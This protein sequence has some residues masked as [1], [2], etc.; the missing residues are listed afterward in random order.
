MQN[1]VVTLDTDGIALLELNRPQVLNVLNRDLM[2]DFE[3]ALAALAT[4]VEVRALLVTGRGEGFC[5]GADL[6]DVS[7][8]AIDAGVV[9]IGGLVAQLMQNYFNPMMQSLYGFPKPVICAVNG[10]AAGGGAAMALCADLV[11]VSTKASMKLVQVPQLGIV[12][13]L[14]ANWLLPRLIGRG[15][16]LGAC[17]LGETINADKLYEWGMVWELAAPQKLMHIAR[18]YAVALANTN[19]QTV[20]ATRELVDKAFSCSYTDMLEAERDMQASLSNRNSVLF[21][22]LRAFRKDE[23]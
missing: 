22:R 20:V 9:R 2:S 16:A 18:G 19:G 5:A 15:R 3:Q 12:A 8:E 17:L 6:S 7:S 10:V 13:D 1:I 4:D 23:P 11:V 14:G 21:D